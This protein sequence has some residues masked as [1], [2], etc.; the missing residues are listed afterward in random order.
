[1]PVPGNPVTTSSTYFEKVFNNSKRNS[2][3]LLDKVGTIIEI[4]EAFTNFF[5]FTKGD[6]IEK[7]FSILFTETDR[8]A[9]LPEKEIETE[10]LSGQAADNNFLVGKDK[11]LT[12]VSGESILIVE[13]QDGTGSILKIIQ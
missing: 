6:I 8:E 11:S 10:L 1:M 7:H 5:G 2:M 3:L 4:N 9:G 12:W 13:N